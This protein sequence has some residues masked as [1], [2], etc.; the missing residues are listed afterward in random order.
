MNYKKPKIDILIF[1]DSDVI[2]NSLDILEKDPIDGG[3]D[4]DYDADGV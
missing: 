3:G 1:I 2:T 4:I